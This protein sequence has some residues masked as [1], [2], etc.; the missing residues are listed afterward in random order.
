MIATLP[1]DSANTRFTG[2]LQAKPGQPM[3][4][5]SVPDLAGWQERKKEREAELAK[6]K[7]VKPKASKLDR[8]PWDASRA[9]PKDTVRRSAS[10]AGPHT[11]EKFRV[12]PSATDLSTQLFS[13]VLIQPRGRAPSGFGRL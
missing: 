3:T 9:T 4:S 5:I 12:S 13:F 1:C 10:A 11:L 2:A 8:P 7:L 6:S